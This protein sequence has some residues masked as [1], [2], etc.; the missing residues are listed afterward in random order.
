MTVSTAA[1][2]KF[3][4]GTDS[5]DEDWAT[6]C[7]TEAVALVT[8]AVGTATVP[9][10]VLDRAVLDTAGNLFHQRSAR[11]GIIGYDSVDASPVHVP[12]NPLRGAERILA[13]Y[14]VRFA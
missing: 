1:L 2:M 6:Q 5:V 11:L 12:L 3:V 13:P 7:V 10:V 8:A 9:E 4:N 14:L